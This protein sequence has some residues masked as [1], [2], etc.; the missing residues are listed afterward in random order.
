MARVALDVMGSDRGPAEIA[1]GAV[2]FA[3]AGPPPV[4]VGRR[5]EIEPELIAAG[6]DL[7]VVHAPEVVEMHDDPARAVRDKPGSSVL[8]AAR[9]VASGEADAFVSAGS[10]GA[11]M[12]AASIVIGR[13][14]GVLRP[15]IADRK[16]V[17]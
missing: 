4:L 16:S 2:M 7:E 10:T 1:A 17:V 5:E 9:L 14:E 8:A 13:I 3:E 11:A 6:A 15:A 12:A